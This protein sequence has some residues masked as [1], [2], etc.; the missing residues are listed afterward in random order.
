MPPL[1]LETRQEVSSLLLN[2]RAPWSEQSGCTSL[3]SDSPEN[4]RSGVILSDLLIKKREIFI[5][6]FEIESL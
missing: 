4:L 3:C 6:V 1:Q 2:P 5:F